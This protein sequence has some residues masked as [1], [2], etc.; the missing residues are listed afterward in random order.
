MFK[1]VLV[2]AVAVLTAS[3]AQAQVRLGAR[4]GFT[5]TNAYGNDIDSRTR[6]GVQLGVASDIAFSNAFSIQPGVVFSQQ[7]AKLTLMKYDADFDMDVEYTDRIRLN[8]VQ[9]PVYVQYKV[10]KFY[11]QAGPYL[12]IATSGESKL[13]EGGAI[14]S[15]FLSALGLDDKKKI[16]FG[17]EPDQINRF[18]FGV[19]F[20]AGFAFKVAQ[21]GIN[22]NLGLTNLKYTDRLN[23]NPHE[24]KNKG[25][26]VA[27]TFLFGNEVSEK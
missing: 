26:L 12:G 3:A 23:N 25:I 18:D 14:G 10:S 27:V 9:I 21:V 4:L 13:A 1:K 6:M 11:V 8:Y 17:N 15:G 19:G 2:I 7:G 22:Y 16:K 5:F 24:M 20:G